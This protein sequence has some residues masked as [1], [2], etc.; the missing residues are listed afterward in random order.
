MLQKTHNRI[1]FGALIGAFGGSSFVIS[2]YPILIG[3][4]FSELTGNA[5]LFTFIYTVPAAILWAIG[6]A[7]TGWLG[8][9]R[10]GAIVMGLCG[11]IIGIIIS[12]KLLGE[13]SNSFALIAGGAAVGL[14][15]GIPAGLLMA[16]AFRR[17]A[18]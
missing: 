17:T 18:E 7:I 5:L 13:A 10:E 16:G 11:L 4:L 3:L 14:L 12:A 8:K 1:I 9:M 15:Y 2:V 6:G